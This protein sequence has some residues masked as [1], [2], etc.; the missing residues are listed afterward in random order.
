MKILH[1]SPK[2]VRRIIGPAR[3]SHK[4]QNGAIM[5]IG[6]SHRYHGA[7][8][9]AMQT[10]ARFVDM[11]HFACEENYR[12]ILPHMRGKLLEFIPV[13]SSELSEYIGHTDV[14][15]MGPGL[16]L[17]PRN[18]RLVNHLIKKFPEKKFVI[19][20]GALRLLDKRL[21]SSKHIVT[22][23]PQEF[24]HVFGHVRTPA[25][26]RGV[27]KKY[28]ATILAKGPISY[29]A[30]KTAY[31]E[32]HT[33]N[34]GLT[35]G[36]TGDVLAGLIAAFFA[37]NDPLTSCKAAGFLIGKTAEA[38][39]KKRSFAYSASDLQDG[40]FTTFGTLRRT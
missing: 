7:P 5:V 10:A 16:A 38:L 35:K 17:D 14:V 34:P 2:D 19:D 8:L 23:N 9:L 40:I 18:K 29:I 33:G 1:T 15:L 27:A 24:K 37:K 36:G 39:A 20:A 6:G 21:L 30:S 31:A 13:F 11:V 25:A 26:V 22:P 12:A 3:F 4:W 28:G 32:N